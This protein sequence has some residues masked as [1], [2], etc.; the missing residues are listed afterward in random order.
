MF[1]KILILICLNLILT[2]ALEN[3]QHQ[4]YLLIS[5]SSKLYCMKMPDFSGRS[6]YQRLSQSYYDELKNYQVIYEEK[7]HANNWITDAFYVRSE[8]LIYVNVYNST[9]ASSDIFTLKHDPISNTWIKTILYQDQSFCLGIAY[10]EEKKELYWTAGKSILSGSSQISTPK[11][12]FNL[13]LAKKLLYLKYDPQTDTVYVSALNYVYACPLKF[14]DCKIIARDLVSVRGLYLDSINRNL[15]VVDHKKKVIKKIRLNSHENQYFADANSIYDPTLIE[16]T[17][18]IQTILGPD[19]VPDIGDVFYMTLFNRPNLNAIIWSEFSGK[20]KMSSLNDTSNYR[21]LFSTNEYTYSVNILDNSTVQYKP[22]PTSTVP[23]TTTTTTTTTIE[24]TTTT[25]TTTT[26]P[27]R[28]W[29]R[30]RVTSTTTIETT[31]ITTTAEIEVT[32]TTVPSTSSIL[33]AL[34]TFS[35]GEETNLSYEQAEEIEIPESTTHIIP[36]TTITEELTTSTTE[37]AQVKNLKYQFVQ[38]IKNDEESEET[39]VEAESSHQIQPIK[40]VTSS[41]SLVRASPQ[42]NVAF[43][44]LIC[45]LC[46]SLV[47][48]II[49]LYI[50]K[51]KQSRDKIVITHEIRN[52]S[53]SVPSQRSALGECSVNL[54]NSNENTSNGLDLEH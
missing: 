27:L 3:S 39:L 5:T 47:I 13:D 23:V 30:N 54:I 10:N 43:Y 38:K 48:N 51:K 14:S 16:T 46:F 22:K 1:K 25:I 11:T 41:T 33:I 17:S 24:I 26:E 40:N 36:T 8:N 52:K 35:L 9:A 50:S 42:L 44:I 18:N 4:V 49:L 53:E 2:E 20:I 21:V 29:T 31:T 7:N 28:T 15:Y 45:L 34:A 12:L 19:T 6:H 37:V 32:T